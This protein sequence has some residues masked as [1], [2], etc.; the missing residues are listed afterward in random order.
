MCKRIAH[1]TGKIP[2]EI[3][4]MAAKDGRPMAKKAN[5]DRR[6][7][8]QCQVLIESSEFAARQNTLKISDYEYQAPTNVC[9]LFK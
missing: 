2:K 4:V 8:R 7:D 6:M 1:D 9:K 3:V 5:S